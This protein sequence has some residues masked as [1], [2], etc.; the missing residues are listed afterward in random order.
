MTEPPPSI[1]IA[2][3]PVAPLSPARA[4]LHVVLVVC[5]IALAL[6]AL[7]RLESVV[8]VLTLAAL[9]AYVIAPLVHIAERPVRIAGR[10]RHL[11]RGVAIAVVYLGLVGSA[12][13][14]ALLLLPSVSEQAHEMLVRAPSYGQSLVAWEHG[15]SR[16][17]ERLR[18]PSG[19]RQSIDQSMLAA[20]DIAI[21]STRAALVSLVG[22]VLPWLVLIPILAFFLLK[23]AA[24]FRRIILI[25]LPHRMRLRGHRL[26]EDMNAALAAYIRAQLLACVLVGSICGIGFAVLGLP[27]SILLGVL[28][29]VLEFIPLVGPL[30]LAMIA[31][32]VGALHVPMLAVWTVTFLVGVRILEDYVVYPRLMRSGVQLHPLAVIVA[33]LAGAELD[34]VAGMF[35][36]VPVVAIASVVCRHWVE[37]RGG[38]QGEPLTSKENDPVPFGT[39]GFP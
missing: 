9:F 5:G 32:T 39:A 37:W 4:V 28:A 8:L 33:V 22:A 38:E 15:W 11:R 17:Y 19:L 27:Y 29:G 1:A 20:S 3:P 18:I 34:G 36:A 13:A 7:Y 14:G 2:V 25:A 21:G 26:F 23:D 30:L 24:E 35:L 31:A 10:R 16:Y 12:A 6:W